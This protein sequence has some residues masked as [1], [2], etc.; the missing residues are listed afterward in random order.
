MI[1]RQDVLI[2]QVADGELSTLCGLLVL[3][4]GREA[5]FTPDVE[6]QTPGLRLVTE[7]PAVAYQQRP[8]ELLRHEVHRSR[9]WAENSCSSQG[10]AGGLT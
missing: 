4:L 7:K 1:T 9:V 3:L 5:D 6:R 2:L 8:A 10:H